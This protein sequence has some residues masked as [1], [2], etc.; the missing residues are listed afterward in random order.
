MHL[1]QTNFMKSS[2]RDLLVLSRNVSINKVEMEREVETLHKLLMEAESLQN[3]CLV[4]EIIDVN[5]YRIIDNPVKIER[6]IRQIKIKPFIFI[7]NKN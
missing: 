6:M 5:R 3:F 2:N 7:S 1:S 4:N